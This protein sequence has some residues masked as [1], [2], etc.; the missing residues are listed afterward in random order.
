MAMFYSFS[1]NEAATDFDSAS[2]SPLNKESN[3]EYA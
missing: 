1:F 2:I 3:F